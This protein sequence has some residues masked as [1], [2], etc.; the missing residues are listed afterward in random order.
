MNWPVLPKRIEYALKA[1]ICLAQSRPHPRRAQDVARCVGITT[2][3]AARILYS[4]AWAGLAH[5]RRG[6]SGGF[7]L[8]QEPE[9]IR[10]G[11]VMRIFLR[12]PDRTVAASS[13]PFMRVWRKTTAAHRRAWERL[14]VAD[15]LQRTL[16][17]QEASPYVCPDKG[18]PIFIP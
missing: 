1:L 8:A 16:R 13:D 5:S 12:V 2:P 15:L 18:E 10:V 14:T 4:L 7:W 3:Q 9:R 6:S 11:Q 17:N